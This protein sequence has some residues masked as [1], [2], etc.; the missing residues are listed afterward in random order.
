CGDGLVR[1]PIEGC[2]DGDLDDE[3]GCSAVCGAE[4]GW[5]CD[6]AEGEASVCGLALCSDGRDNDG[7]GA[8]D[9]PDDP[10]C[11]TPEDNDEHGGLGCDDGEDNDGDGRTDYMAAGGN[12]D[13]GCTGPDDASEIG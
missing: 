7:D 6:N 10:G 9:F 11:N 4:V 3:D 12:G 2:D 8:M 13:P 1:D 5:N